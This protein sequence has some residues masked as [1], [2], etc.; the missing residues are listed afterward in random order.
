MIV[1]YYLESR[2]KRRERRE[3]SKKEID[4]KKLDSKKVSNKKPCKKFQKFK[5]RFIEQMTQFLQRIVFSFQNLGHSLKLSVSGYVL[6]LAVTMIP[7]ILLGTKYMLDLNKSKTRQMQL[8]DGLKKRCA[9]K[10]AEEVASKWNP[11]LS[12]KEQKESLLRIADEIYNREKPYMNSLMGDALKGVDVPGGKVELK[13]TDRIINQITKSQV[14][15]RYMIEIPSYDTYAAPS[16]MKLYKQMDEVIRGGNW[17]IF[18]VDDWTTNEDEEN[19]G[20]SEITNNW[21]MDL[22]HSYEDSGTGKVTQYFTIPEKVIEGMSDI[23]TPTSSEV[24]GE[25][26]VRENPNT[27]LSENQFKDYINIL[28]SF[29]EYSLV[30]ILLEKNNFQFYKP[31]KVNL[32][33]FTSTQTIIKKLNIPII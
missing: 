30:D 2:K 1:E 3:M 16:A 14:N 8:G 26:K 32:P 29:K 9:Q 27:G 22:L 28:F 11:A 24:L 20:V 17:S 13:A 4:P 31:E 18:T 10:I 25:Y 21:D 12:Y 23:G 6:I 19:Q 15:N 5:D 33:N 7:V